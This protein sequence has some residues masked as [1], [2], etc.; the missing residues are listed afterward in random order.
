MPRTSAAW[1]NT[2]SKIPVAPGSP[3]PLESRFNGLSMR[4]ITPIRR[5]NTKSLTNL[6]GEAQLRAAEAVE[7]ANNQ[8]AHQTPVRYAAPLARKIGTQR[9]SIGSPDEIA[10]SPYCEDISMMSYVPTPPPMRP[11][12]GSLAPLGPTISGASQGSSSSTEVSSSGSDKA[13]IAPTTHTNLPSMIPTPSYQYREAATPAKWTLDDPDLPSPFIRRASTAP[14]A[15]I[16]TATA[17]TSVA[18]RRPLVPTSHENTRTATSTLP[19]RVPAKSLVPRSRSGTL[20]QQVL[21]TNAG[22]ASGEGTTGA[23]LLSKFRAGAGR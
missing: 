7:A 10:N 12:R 2:P 22:R 8:L 4:N 9:S 5:N 14:T 21:K 1:E 3:N 20:H 17:V 6:R 23:T 16:P 19:H 18:E 13:S 11:R 15:V